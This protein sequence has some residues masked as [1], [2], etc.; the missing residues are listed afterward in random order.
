MFPVLFRT[1]LTLSLTR[2]YISTTI[3]LMVD[4]SMYV[5]YNIFTPKKVS[6]LME[7]FA[8]N[9]INMRGKC[10]DI[11][12]GPG[13]ITKHVLLPVFDQNAVV[14]GKYIYIYIYIINDL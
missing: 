9:L 6:N 12:C 3:K 5:S 7:E 4:P 10:M 1:N 8:D 14:I 11:G 13:N 2:R